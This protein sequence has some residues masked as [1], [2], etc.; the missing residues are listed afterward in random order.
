VLDQGLLTVLG[1][2]A[3]HGIRRARS[4]TQTHAMQ[5]MSF[6]QG[7]LQEDDITVVLVK[8]ETGA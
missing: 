4:V 3:G 8:R 7:A 1:D 2:A 6:A 5:R